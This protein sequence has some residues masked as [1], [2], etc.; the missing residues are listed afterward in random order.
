LTH[1]AS[2]FALGGLTLLASETIVPSRLYPWLSLASGLMVAAVGLV[3]LRRRLQASRP[4]HAHDPGDHGHHG[5]HGHDH[6]GHAHLPESGDRARITWRSL[7]ALGVSGGLLPCPSA[8]IAL[9]G[10]ISLD[11]V[12]FGLLLV[13]AFSLGL[14]AVLPGIG[15][16]LL[17]SARLAR[18]LDLGRWA[19][20]VPAPLARD[21]HLARR[22][23]ALLPVG[24][25][26]VVTA[27]G[28]AIAARAAGQTLLGL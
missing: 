15:L 5:H 14:A 1:T 28:L 20:R 4:G 2:V 22:A 9:L 27:L 21:G 6:H 25:A 24:S 13:T 11:R 3:L 16:A 18:A 8:L 19:A 10:A 17:Y 23:V 26:L 12:G 7:L